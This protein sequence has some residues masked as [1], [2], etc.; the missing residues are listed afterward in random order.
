MTRIQHSGKVRKVH[1]QGFLMHR[2]AHPHRVR[3]TPLKCKNGKASVAEALPSFSA[4][5]GKRQDVRPG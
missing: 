2:R 5:A 4:S 1:P 3:K